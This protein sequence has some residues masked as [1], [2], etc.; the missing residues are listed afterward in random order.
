MPTLFFPQPRADTLLIKDPATGNQSLLQ[1]V[2]S[3][4]AMRYMVPILP[5]I[6][7]TSLTKWLE[8]KHFGID[9][10]DSR[11]CNTA[12]STFKAA[13]FTILLRLGAALAMLH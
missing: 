13:N 2:R 5:Q 9:S 4:A 8:N 11:F 10:Q 6:S 3:S 12:K 7:I 1:N